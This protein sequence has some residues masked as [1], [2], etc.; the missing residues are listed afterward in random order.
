VRYLPALLAPL[1]FLVVYLWD[2]IRRL[3]GTAKRCVF[4]PMRAP[5]TRTPATATTEGCSSPSTP[6]AASAVPRV[7]ILLPL[8]S[9][10]TVRSSSGAETVT[11]GANGELP[12]S[13]A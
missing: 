1:L 13:V 8:E 6:G 4:T 3:G 2:G 10:F 11:L 9:S 5:G 7:L 12:D